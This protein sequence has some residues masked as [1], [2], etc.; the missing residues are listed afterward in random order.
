MGRSISNT[1]YLAS[2]EKGV[3]GRTTIAKARAPLVTDGRIGDFYVDTVAKKLY[4]P[5]SAAGWPDN[6]LI[7][8]DEGWSP[9]LG[10]A[11]DGNRRVYRVVDWQGGEGSK[12]ATGQYVGATGLVPNIADAIDIRGPVGP[13]MVID[14]ITAAT[15]DITDA[16]LIPAAQPGDDNE[17]RVAVEVFDLGGV[18]DRESLPAA[19]ASTIRKRVKRV[20]VGHDQYVRAA[21]EPADS[22]KFRSQDR[23]TDAGDSD[24][25]NGGWWVYSESALDTALQPGASAPTVLTD[26]Q[27]DYS[28]RRYV[29]KSIWDGLNSPDGWGEMLSV[30]LQEANDDV[31]AKGGGFVNC[32]GGVIL[33]DGYK[34]ASTSFDVNRRGGLLLSDGAVVHWRGVP[35]K[36]IWKNA[37][38]NWRSIVS[39]KDPETFSFEGIIFDGDQ[40][41]HPCVLL[42]EDDIRGELIN[43]WGSK[44][45]IIQHARIINC[46]FLRSGH[47]GIGVQSS[48]VMDLLIHGNYG[49]DI[50]GDFI[51]IKDFPATRPKIAIKLSGNTVGSIGTNYAARVADGDGAQAAFDIRGACQAWGNVVLGLDSYDPS[52]IGNDG[53][54]VNADVTSQG[55]RGGDRS[56]L[57]NNRVVSKKLNNEGSASQKRIR[58]LVVADDTVSVTG[59]TAENCYIGGIV[60]IVG[61][62]DSTPDCI[63]ISG[64]HAKNCR[65]S[66][67]TA[68]GLSLNGG[69]KGHII[70][71]VV[72]NCDTGFQC[73]AVNSRGVITQIGCTL[74]NNLSPDVMRQN[75]FSFENSGNT[76]NTSHTSA[77]RNNMSGA[78]TVW[79]E[80]SPEVY[81][82]STRDGTVPGGQIVGRFGFLSDDVSGAGAGVRA[83]ID[84]VANGTSHSGDRLSLKTTGASGALTEAMV[85][86]EE[87]MKTPVG[88]LPVMAP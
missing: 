29:T 21:S 40:H 78:L 38:D 74:G 80:V 10:V 87:Y 63:Q 62:G 12:P 67:G 64:Y 83:A 65:S 2:P 8:G 7:K 70:S 85:L 24:S 86:S 72:E 37:A 84:A 54:R 69:T 30:E 22:R 28:L 45:G 13:E 9:V 44:P 77:K 3:D 68:L 1:V 32:P 36:T 23:W 41:N 51:D 19:A 88:L 71:G 20:R 11:T 82:R 66:D 5:K 18:L 75:D 60:G 55:R 14:N 43:F 52:Q 39:V 26:W 42:A 34:G 15:T 25:A 46:G 35:G 57:T 76:S 6:G 27:P 58:G 48:S 49:D 16:T 61:D 47:Y 4:G 31:A 50:G 53:F 33:I 79:D 17:K 56:I 81:V 59:F 73:N